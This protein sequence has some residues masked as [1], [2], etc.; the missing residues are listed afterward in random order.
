MTL[1]ASDAFAASSTCSTRRRDSSRGVL[2]D[3][4]SGAGRLERVERMV[5]VD[6][7]AVHVELLNEYVAKDDN[8]GLHQC[9]SAK[10]AE[11]SVGV[12]EL[13]EAAQAMGQPQPAVRRTGQPG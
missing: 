9:Q 13:D 2:G 10:E 3:S 6:E 8:E 5:R 1:A 12:T 11:R 7:A 4:I